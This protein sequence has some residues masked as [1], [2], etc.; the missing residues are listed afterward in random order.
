MRSLAPS[1]WGPQ[2]WHLLHAIAYTYPE[3][4]TPAQKQSVNALYEALAEILPCQKCAQNLAK[5]LEEY[6]PDVSSREALQRWTHQLHLRV[7]SRTNPAK[8]EYPFK[9]VQRKFDVLCQRR[10][11]LRW[12]NTGLKA[13]KATAIVGLAYMLLRER[14]PSYAKP[15]ALF[16][17][18]FVALALHRDNTCERILTT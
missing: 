7:T 12:C 11:Q 18:T 1:T 5:E 2:A 13:F 9:R 3:E 16:A 8:S 10:S 17:A 15:A 4:P 6:P 14:Q